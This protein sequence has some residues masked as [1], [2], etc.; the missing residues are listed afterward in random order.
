MHT[1]ASGA[2]DHLAELYLIVE[3]EGQVLGLGKVRENLSYLNGL[4]ISEVR[5]AVKGLLEE[6]SWEMVLKI[7]KI[8]GITPLLEAAEILN[9]N[10]RIWQLGDA[11]GIIEGLR[12]VKSPAEL[13]KIELAAGYV[14]EGMRAGIE[15][16]KIGN[17]ENDII[18]AMMGHA[19]AA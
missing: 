1:A 6:V 14:D 7:V 10:N 17:T 4:K 13:A 16:I 19:I 3:D 8:V 12:A 2:V 9:Q 18:S 11:T 15:A 5:A